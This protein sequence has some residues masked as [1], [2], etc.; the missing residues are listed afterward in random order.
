MAAVEEFDLADSD[1][2]GGSPLT[3]GG[4]RR[5]SQPWPWIMAAIALV[6][7]GAANA[8]PVPIAYGTAGLDIG[9]LDLDMRQEPTTVWTSDLRFPEVVLARGDRAV[10]VEDD[11]GSG[12]S[13]VGLDLSNGA[14]VWRYYDAGY[15]CTW[16]ISVGCVEAPGSPE[17]TLVQIDV[18]D[19]SRHT[20][21]HP[22]AVAVAATTDGVV[23]VERSETPAEPVLMLE[24]DGSQRWRVE[25][26][27]VE[28]M[29]PPFWI[30]LAVIDDRVEVY[31]ASSAIELATGAVSPVTR[32]RLH[33]DVD[34]EISGDTSPEVFV[35]T[36][37]GSV[38]LALE[39]LLIPYDDDLGGAVTLTQDVSGRLTATLRAD[40]TDLW[41][42]SPSNEACQPAARLLGTLITHCWGAPGNRVVGWDLRTG[43]ERW[44]LGGPTSL[45]GATHDDLLVLDYVEGNL[46]TL[47]P[48]DG[49]QGWTTPLRV[50]DSATV[51]ELS[52][53]LLLSTRSS[54]VRLL[55]D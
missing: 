7:L 35:H 42:M 6:G 51:V 8:G 37:A 26:D 40:G 44:R 10:V 36:G 12:R 19:G 20:R 48:L 2:D 31:N 3:G 43:E 49:S 41:R 21:P 55:W 29:S 32:W 24:A 30:Q 38:P 9:L 46:F 11:N 1:D 25:L 27:V 45:L 17:A 53:G 23:V 39:E 13:V 18:V 15:T 54:V 14:E 47:D 50:D 5:G 52:N 16:G 28:G 22:E 34:V 33:P 4:R